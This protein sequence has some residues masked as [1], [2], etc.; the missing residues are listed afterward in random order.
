MH[1][2]K[3]YTLKEFILWTRR[4]I[5][6]LTLLAVIP[7]V[8]YHV[9]GWTFLSI[10]W[11]PVALMGTA[12][13]FIVGFKNNASYSRL[14]EARQIYGGIINWSRAFG[15]MVRDFSPPNLDSEVRTVFYR[16][17]AW[18]TALRYQ[19][20]EPRLWENMENPENIEYRQLYQTPERERKLEDELIKYL[21]QKEFDHVLGK[22]NRATQLMALQSAHL[23]KLAKSGN[24]TEFEASQLQA[25]ITAFYDH[26]GRAERIKNFPYPRNFSTIATILLDIF[27]LLVPYGLLND[28]EKLGN[29]TVLEGLTIWLN[30][31]F[32]LLLTWAFR[33]LDLVGES[34]VNPFEG[35]ANDV[36]ISN[37]SRTI[38]IDLREMLNEKDLPQ[39]VVAVNNILM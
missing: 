31:P 14:W 17:F 24:F 25:V 30:I 18:L 38:E 16:H 1:A 39:A 28:F 6:K 29:G 7:T 21:S 12:V 22:K 15:V 13:S 3:R 11:V 23:N 35:S 9:L 20:R 10:T 8:L 27:I 32:S 4:Y 33:S 34:S 37:I 19:L 26:Q 2:G 5:Y 36:P